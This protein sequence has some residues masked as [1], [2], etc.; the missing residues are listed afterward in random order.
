MSVFP[1]SVKTPDFRRA[2]RIRGLV[3]VGA[4]F[5][6][7]LL[8]SVWARRRARPEVSTPPAPPTTV[9]VV[10]F[11]N[12]VDMI[13]TLGAA[14]LLTPR[15]LLRGITADG[16]DSSGHVDVSANGHVHYSFQSAPGQ[17]PQPPREPGTLARRPYCGR[18][19][20]DVGKSG[21]VA[22][23]DIA[24]ASCSPHPSD[25]LPEPHCGPAEVWAYA[26][27]RGAKTKFPAHIEYYR[28]NAGPAW[29]FEGSHSSLRFSLYGDCKRELDGRDAVNVAP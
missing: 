17:G 24:D 2:D 16:V 23:L 12:T 14:R 3:I 5:V 10:G 29:R 28:A 13:K 26:A 9:G 19:T 4:T 15:N 18:Q 6:L 25:P 1:V 11:P 20:V 22:E 27:T 8:V 7:C 21:L